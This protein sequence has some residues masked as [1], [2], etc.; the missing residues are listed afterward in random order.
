M[1]D[2]TKLDIKDLKAFAYDEGVKLEI[3]KQNLNILNQEI[4]K[5]I[6]RE[7]KENPVLQEEK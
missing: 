6:S 3:A 7:L 5:R 2:I 1:I 4:Q